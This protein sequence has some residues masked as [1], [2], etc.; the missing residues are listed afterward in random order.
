MALGR[1]ELGD[2]AVERQEGVARLDVAGEG[3]VVDD[4]V[5]AR[6]DAGDALMLEIAERADLPV[7]LDLRALFAETGDQR[8]ERPVG[9][10]VAPGEAGRRTVTTC[11]CAR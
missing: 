11:P 3:M 1:R 7:D 5:E 6:G 2:E 9:A 4:Q 8:R 10:A